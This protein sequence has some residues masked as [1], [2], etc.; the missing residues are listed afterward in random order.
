ML[1]VIIPSRQPEFLQRTINDLLVKSEGKIEIIVIFDGIWPE[2]MLEN[3]QRVRIIHQGTT[4]NNLGMRAG[5]NAGVAIAEGDYIMKIDEHCL[6]SQGYDKRLEQTCE[7]DWLVVPRRYR[8]DVESWKIIEDGRSPID[9]MYVSYPYRK[10]YDSTSGLYGAEDR[11]K[12]Y[13][14]KMY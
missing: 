1:S 10:L 7:D 14:R 4:H 6:V 13:D 3:D 11:Q 8:L 5:I 9:Y 2:T 12:Y